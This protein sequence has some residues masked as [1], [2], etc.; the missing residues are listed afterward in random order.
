MVRLTNFTCIFDATYYRKVLYHSQKDCKTKMV[1]MC[2]ILSQM[3]NKFE[4]VIHASNEGV[5]GQWRKENLCASRELTQMGM[6]T[7]QT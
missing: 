3:D 4:L 7:V 2:L 1:M 5:R 6:K